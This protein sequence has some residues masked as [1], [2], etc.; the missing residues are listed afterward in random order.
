MFNNKFTKKDPIADAAL[1]VLESWDDDEDDDVKRADA[2]LRRMKAKPIEADKKT[3][4]DKEIGKLAKKTPKE[5]DEEVVTEG[6]GPKEKQHTPYSSIEQKHKEGSEFSKQL[7]AKYDQ[8]KKAKAAAKIG[9]KNEDKWT[10]I[11]D[12]P[13]K[14]S[15]RSKSSAVSAA[16]N[17]AGK[18][19]KGAQHKLDVA[20]PKGKLTGAD[21]KKLRKEDTEQLDEI[22]KKLA[23]G[24]MRA[25]TKR[26]AS[27]SNPDSMEKKMKRHDAYDTATKKYHGEKGVKVKATEEVEIQE[28]TL[29][30]AESKK[31]EEIVKSMKKGASG[32]K[33]RYG[34]RAKEVMYATATKQAKKVAEEVNEAKGPTSDYGLE[35]FAT[36]ETSTTPLSRV[37]DLARTAMS[38][39]KN[40]MLGKAGT[41]S[42][43]ID[44]S[45][46]S[47][48][49]LK[50]RV[51]G[52]K[53]D[54]VGPGADGK[55]TKVKYTPGPK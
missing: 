53:K 52:G 2:E 17:A 20:E 33:E 42:E 4:P 30:P 15:K 8:E 44:P 29:T 19:L 16:A 46:K 37:K 28:K 39:L 3:D 55:S 21:F 1:K 18:G 49:T 10:D 43:E 6:S 41:T 5:V 50:G 24:Y 7:R 11:A 14:K 48:D 32:F 23:V 12:G 31:K 54:D 40:E 35:T 26:M 27:L 13:W 36:N 34:K 38:K 47:T 25:N 22:S 51:A 45:V 9:M